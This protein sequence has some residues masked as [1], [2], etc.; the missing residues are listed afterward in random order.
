VPAD[1]IIV[2]EMNIHVDESM[3]DP[4]AVDVEKEPSEKF[5]KPRRDEDDDADDKYAV[6][7][8]DNHYENPD[9]IL[10]TGSKVMNGSGRAVV[11]SVGKNTR[12]SRSRGTQELKLHEQ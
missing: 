9:P 6:V 8:N 2:E 7:H 3:Y 5:D 11:C 1:C 12:L 10:L 4:R